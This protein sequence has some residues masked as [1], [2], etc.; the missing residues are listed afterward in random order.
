MMLSI[1]NK[2]ICVVMELLVLVI[3]RKLNVV[4]AMCYVPPIYN[5]FHN[6]VYLLYVFNR[7]IPLYNYFY[8]AVY[9]LYVIH[10]AVYL[11]FMIHIGQFKVQLICSVNCRKESKLQII[12]YYYY[13]YVNILYIYIYNIY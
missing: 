7:Y 4:N 5:Y 13:I 11:L 8:N 2:L 3:Y 9:L 6:A 12:E 1:T 10:N